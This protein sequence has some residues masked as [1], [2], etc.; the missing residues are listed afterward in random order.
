MRRNGPQTLADR[1]ESLHR[2]PVRAAARKRR[3]EHSRRRTP[4][5][6]NPITASHPSPPGRSRCRAS[7]PRSRPLGWHKLSDRIS[8]STISETVGSIRCAI[9]WETGRLVK[10][11]V[12]KS[13][14][15]RA[16]TSP[17]TASGM[18]CPA[19]RDSDPGDVGGGC[20]VARDDRRRVSGRD[21]EQ[22]E[23]EQ[24]HDQDDGDGLS[25][26][27]GSSRIAS[28]GGGGGGRG[29]TYSPHVFVTSHI[30]GNGAFTT[31]DSDCSARPD[32]P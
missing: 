6:R 27:V 21:I 17:R 26:C 31:P 8:V 10:I 24:G 1:R 11:E 16:R 15:A 30:T 5:W 2:Q 4:V 18:A 14:A 20:L 22:A 29:G 25:G 32:T 19:Q 13:P 9:M 28:S 3:R 12:P 23:D 7:T